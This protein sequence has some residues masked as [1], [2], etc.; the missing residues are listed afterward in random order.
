MKKYILEA[1]DDLGALKFDCEQPPVRDFTE[2][3]LAKLVWQHTPDA[4]LH[5]TEILSWV[6]NNVNK[7]WKT[8]V[9]TW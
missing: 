1:R 6:S 5:G 9:K 2:D 4:K 7:H 3:D 8:R